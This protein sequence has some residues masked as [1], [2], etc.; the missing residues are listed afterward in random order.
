MRVSEMGA[1][2]KTR[3]KV[4]AALALLLSPLL[5]VTASLWPD[6]GMAHEGIETIGQLLIAV[7][8]LGRADSMLYIG[9]RKSSE[10]VTVGPYSVC[11]NPLYLFSLAG[12]LGAG[13]MYGSVLMGL[14]FG[15]VYFL[16]FDRLIGLEEA[17]LR[18]RFPAAFDDYCAH[19]PR[20]WPRLSRWQGVDEVSVRPQLIYKTLRDASVFVLM[21]PLFEGIEWLQNSGVLP[22]LLRLP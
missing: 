13:F 8:L 3:R 14:L 5:L 10:L 16:V 7:C 17:H 2:Q 12:T 20:W 4:L 21:V 1:V 19:T 11:R 18:S 9:G 6:V 22:V 15:T